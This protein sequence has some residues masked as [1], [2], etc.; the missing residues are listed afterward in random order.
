MA[1][2]KQAKNITIEVTDKYQL[3][4]GKKLEKYAQILNVEATS[5]NLSLASAKKIVAKGKKND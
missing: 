3:Q 1:I 2:T 4:V 5:N